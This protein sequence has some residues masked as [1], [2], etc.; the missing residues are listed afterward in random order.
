MNNP[1]SELCRLPN[2]TPTYLTFYDEAQFN[3][4]YATEFCRKKHDL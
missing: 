3:I 2:N 1:L 4:D